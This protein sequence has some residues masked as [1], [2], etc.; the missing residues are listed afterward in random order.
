MTPTVAISNS[1]FAETVCE[2]YNRAINEDLV[3]IT[4]KNVVCNICFKECSR[5]SGRLKKLFI[6]DRS[7]KWCGNKKCSGANNTS[8]NKENKI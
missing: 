8:L 5:L 6:Q 4:D 1:I 3:C 7:G 2:K